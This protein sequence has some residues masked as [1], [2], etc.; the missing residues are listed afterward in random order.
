MSS[1]SPLNEAQQRPLLS[2]TKYADKPLSN[3][4]AI[5]NAAES[6]TIFPKYPSDLSPSQVKLIRTS[7]AR[8]RD[9]LMRVMEGLGIVHG[10]PAFASLHSLRVTPGFVQISAQEMAP[11]YLRGY[12]EVPES[13]VPQLQGVYAELEGL[14]GDWTS[15]WRKVP[16]PICSQGYSV[17]SSQSSELS[18][19]S[20]WTGS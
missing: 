5:L 20:F 16:Q 19:S 11:H 6:K 3:V 2:G 13:V 9:Q 10:G 18:C 15:P 7:A 14:Q 4:E 8:F 17:S 12:G 1:A